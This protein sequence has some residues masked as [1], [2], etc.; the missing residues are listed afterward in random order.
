MKLLKRG[1]L[2]ALFSAIL[3]FSVSADP[4][5]DAIISFIPGVGSGYGQDELPDVVLGPP[6]GGGAS[7]GSMDVLSLGDGGEIILE[8]KDNIV[9]NG[10]GPD[11]IIFENA[12]FAGGN[13]E[14]TFAEVAFVEVSLNGV[15]YYRFPNDYNPDGE[16]VNNPAN[17]L[18]FAGVLPA[19]SH[20]DNGID[21]TDP[22]VSGG[23]LFDL[24]DVGLDKIRFIKIIDTNEGDEAARDSDGDL[25]Y[26]P[27]MPGGDSAGFDLDAV[28]AVYSTDISPTQAP[29]FSFCLNLSSNHFSAGDD[30]ILNTR[31]FNPGDTLHDID[32]YIFLDIY[33]EYY[34]Y[35]SWEQDIDFMTI[36]ILSGISEMDILNFKWPVLDGHADNILIWGGLTTPEGIVSGSIS[37]VGFKY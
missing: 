10:P 4:F 24:D 2:M 25:I 12:F 36:N 35:P 23:D 9:A 37:N 29:A 6:L 28:A 5:P 1:F 26:D 33:G 17:W 16:P 32:L 19:L 11:L 21:P 20:P 7:A 3:C 8:F 22:L 27:G 18:G 13:T 15:D 34:F 14:N 30:F 31:C